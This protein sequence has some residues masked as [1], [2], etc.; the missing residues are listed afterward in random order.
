MCMCVCA[1]TYVCVCGYK[2]LIP[3]TYQNPVSKISIFLSR[4][5]SYLLK[6]PKSAREMDGIPHYLGKVLYIVDIFAISAPLVFVL[7]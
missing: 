2:T 6:H 1:N 3:S 7:P 5:V 4:N